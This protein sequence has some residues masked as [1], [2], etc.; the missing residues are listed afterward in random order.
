M[1]SRT[2]QTERSP[3]RPCFTY[4]KLVPELC[5]RPLLQKGWAPRSLLLHEIL[6]HR[7]TLPPLFPLLLTWAS[8]GA[9]GVLA[10]SLCTWCSE[11]LLLLAFAGSFS[12]SKDMRVSSAEEEIHPQQMKS[13]SWFCSAPSHS[14]PTRLILLFVRYLCLYSW[15]YSGQELLPQSS[16]WA[17]DACGKRFTFSSF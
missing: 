3:H 15:Y 9:M 1:N 7:T 16:W 17:L 6:C 12:F 11:L 10:K 8:L 2:V 14:T 13:T 5:S 4:R